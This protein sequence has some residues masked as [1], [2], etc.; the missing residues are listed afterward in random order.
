MRILNF[1]SLCIDH[2]YRVPHFVRPGETLPSLS[3]QVFAGGK[4]FNQSLA[5]ARA[6]VPV[7]HAGAVGPDGA[8]L[9]DMLRR[10]GGDVEQIVRRETPTGHAVIQI[11]PQGENAIVLCPG[12]NRTL[13]PAQIDATLDRFGPGDLLLLQNEISEP[14]YLVERAL[15]RGLRIVMNPAPMDE[16]VKSLP[17]EAL[18]MIIVNQIEAFDLTGERE[19]EG[20]LRSLRARMPASTVVLTLG[21]DGAIWRDA[22]QRLHVPAMPVQVVD[23]TGAGDTFTG[24]L[25]ASLAGGLPVETAMRRAVCAAGLCVSRAGAADSIPAATAVDE[26]LE[27]LSRQP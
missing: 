26:R 6:G 16:V 12:A 14:A 11:D 24:Y 25:L 17:L 1:G 22:D 23:T 7:C 21:S 19:P 10:E 20:M 13:S 8:W 2:V 4:G 18:A 3:Y 9:L 15:A 5:I 27:L